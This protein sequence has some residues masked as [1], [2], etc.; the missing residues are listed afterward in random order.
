MQHPTPQ[1]EREPNPPKASNNTWIGKSRAYRDKGGKKERG[2]QNGLAHG[3]THA[4]MQEHARPR[5]RGSV[6][7]SKSARVHVRKR[8]SRDQENETKEA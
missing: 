1:R 7:A 5:A 8:A 6:H 4:G 2:H 3:N